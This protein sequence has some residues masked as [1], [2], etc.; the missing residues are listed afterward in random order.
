MEFNRLAKLIE[1]EGFD[2]ECLQTVDRYGSKLTVQFH[3]SLDAQKFKQE[4]KKIK[5]VGTNY[6]VWSKV[7]KGGRPQ[8]CS[9]ITGGAPRKEEGFKKESLSGL[10]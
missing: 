10:D 6:L 5:I 2:V 7:S 4:F 3:T 9:Y 1:L 8:I